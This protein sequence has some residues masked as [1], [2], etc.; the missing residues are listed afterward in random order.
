ML[1]SNTLPLEVS[2]KLYREKNFQ[3]KNLFLD[4]FSFEKTR[5]DG[6]LGKLILKMHNGLSY[7]DVKVDKASAT[8]LSLDKRCTLFCP[9]NLPKDFI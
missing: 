7:I 4:T 8:F 2:L 5:T 3:P 1:I 6:F 9:P